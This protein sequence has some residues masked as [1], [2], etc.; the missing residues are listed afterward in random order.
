MVMKSSVSIACAW[1]LCS[2]TT[3]GAFK[4]SKK[5]FKEGHPI[6]GLWTGL[7]GGLIM[8]PIVDVFTLGGTMDAEQGTKAVLDT[9]SQYESA[10]QRQPSPVVAPVRPSSLPSTSN[11]GVGYTRY[12]SPGNDSLHV[13]DT[14]PSAGAGNSQGN[15]NGQTGQGHGDLVDGNLNATSCVEPRAV[16]GTLL[17]GFENKCSYK[18]EV[19]WCVENPPKDAWSSA[20]DCSRNSFGGTTVQA[21]GETYAQ[22][23]GARVVYGACRSPH[24]P[25]NGK[26]I[27][28]K[29]VFQC[30]R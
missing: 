26:Y 13:I 2:C 5:E 9:A 19:M 11:S 29:T 4:E 23:S 12:V 30:S 20:F 27:G 6:A 25:V 15:Q 3:M 22:T 21:N 10:R 7:V 17:G 24:A 8:G 14:S 1:L 28:G 16:N 18:V